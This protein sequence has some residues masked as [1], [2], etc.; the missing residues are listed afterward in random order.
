MIIISLRRGSWLNDRVQ[1]NHILILDNRDVNTRGLT[2]F[3]QF[4]TWY[5]GWKSAL[6]KGF[7]GIRYNE[8]FLKKGNFYLERSPYSLPIYELAENGLL[9]NM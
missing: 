4:L 1:Q 3:C 8:H 7:L 9:F 5:Y 6:G 2:G